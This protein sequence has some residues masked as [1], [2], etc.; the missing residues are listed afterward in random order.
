MHLQ[1]CDDV[2]DPPP[3][4]INLYTR[5]KF[6]HRLDFLFNCIEEGKGL[7]HIR[8]IEAAE[9]PEAQEING[10]DEF[11]ATFETPSD[12][13]TRDEHSRNTNDAVVEL[14]T[15]EVSEFPVTDTSGKTGKEG[16]VPSEI[17]EGYLTTGQ[18]QPELERSLPSDVQEQSS[19]SQTL[20]HFKSAEG[21]RSPASN[22]EPSRGVEVGVAEEGD[23]IDYNEEDGSAQDSSIG[24]STVQG[25]ALNSDSNEIPAPLLDT[26]SSEPT[27]EDS[28]KSVNA[29]PKYIA[30]TANVSSEIEALPKAAKGDIYHEELEDTDSRID[31]GESSTRLDIQAGRTEQSFRERETQK[32]DPSDVLALHDNEKFITSPFGFSQ[33][34]YDV[35]HIEDEDF[36]PFDEEVTQGY[37]ASPE[38]E[39]HG[40]EENLEPDPKESANEKIQPQEGTISTEGSPGEIDEDNNEFPPEHSDVLDFGDALGETGVDL[41][42]AGNDQTDPDLQ[43]PTLSQWD[44][45]S[46]P[47]E[48]EDN[49][50][51]ITYED[52]E[53]FAKVSTVELNAESSPNSLKRSRSYTNLDANETEAQG[54]HSHPACALP[55]EMLMLC[56]HLDIKRVR[57]S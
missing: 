17:T 43:G 7:V 45:K 13:Q 8:T 28:Q 47:G 19:K 34:Q 33:P 26:V 25:N 29:S 20:S 27:I 14:K 15:T 12:Q 40:S 23:L 44:S 11:E 57:S 41:P 54:E 38:L 39:D 31:T 6:S 49:L 3:L 1:E 24:S 5:T 10:E 22:L 32:E 51:E 48:P 42:S 56:K 52:E 55:G 21:P 30:P 35:G 37:D 36:I 16:T 53:E 9:E 50:D 18:K 2:T 46:L 4:Y